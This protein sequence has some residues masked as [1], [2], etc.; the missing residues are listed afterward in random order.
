MISEM[1]ENDL[2]T[3]VSTLGFSPVLDSVKSMRYSTGITAGNG[4][5]GNGLSNNRIFGSP[6]IPNAFKNSQNSGV[7][8]AV[9]HHKVR[10][11]IDTSGNANNLGGI[12]TVTQL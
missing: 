6:G 12:V 5:S 2:K 7:A 3:M 1:T 8:N 11:Y 9:L 10:Q 4:V